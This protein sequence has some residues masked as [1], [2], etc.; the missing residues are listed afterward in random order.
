M[1]TMVSN[2]SVNS[3]KGILTLGF[4]LPH[5]LRLQGKLRQSLVKNRNLSGSYTT[6]AYILQP[7][8]FS[9]C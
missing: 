4:L 1:T 9:L 3:D 5:D 8:V 2:L 6:A 7:H